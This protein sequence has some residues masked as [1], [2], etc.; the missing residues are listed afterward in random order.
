[1]N[2]DAQEY[3]SYRKNYG[4]K[5]SREECLKRIYSIFHLHK[6]ELLINCISHIAIKFG[7]NNDIEMIKNIHKDLFGI[8]FKMYFVHRSALNVMYQLLLEFRDFSLKDDSKIIRPE[9]LAE[10]FLLINE[11][12]DIEYDE[13]KKNNNNTETQILIFYGIKLFYGIVGPEDVQAK[14]FYFRK[15]YEN[16]YKSGKFCKEIEIFESDFKISFFE[17]MN[18]LKSLTERKNTKEIFNILIGKFSIDI[19]EI[20]S[21]WDNRLPKLPIPFDF[22]FLIDYPIVISKDKKYV[23]NSYFLFLALIMKCF[24]VLCNKDASPNFRGI[25]NK[26]I[27]ESVVKDFLSSIF[28]GKDIK[29][30]NLF[31]NNNNEYADWGMVFKNFIFLFEIK[32][33]TISVEKKY[34]KDIKAFYKDLSKKYIDEQGISQ[35]LKSILALDKNFESFCEIN[36]LKKRNYIVLPL[37][38]V[39]DDIFEIVGV[40]DYM[41]QKYIELVGKKKIYPKNFILSAND[42]IITFTDLFVFSQKKYIHKHK[43]RKLIGYF[44]NRLPFRM[45][46]EEE[47]HVEGNKF[48]RI[49]KMLKGWLK[50]NLKFSKG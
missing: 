47:E 6:R 12:W 28:I 31:Y 50:R 33:G 24:Y 5:L 27:F 7:V 11:L 45:F 48:T 43:I 34:G 32:S 44:R 1:M 36:K 42:A 18:I 19:N 3:L 16:V 14:A 25:V 26:E 15:I 17:Y 13:L 35:Q 4:K 22:K 37:L 9:D 46:I 21:K 23:I 30:L 20:E 29:E 40:N 2:I 8:D 38:I 10:L 41:R 39:Y 49:F